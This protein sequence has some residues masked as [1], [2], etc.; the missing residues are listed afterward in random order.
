MRSIRSRAVRT[1]VRAI[2]AIGLATLTACTSPPTRFYTLG[3]APQP[4]IANGTA[5][6]SFPID[7]R[8]V[9]VPVAVARS[10]LV[11]Q[12]NPSQVKV[13]EDDRWA[14]SLQ[15]EIRYA[16]I[17]GVSQRAGAPG[18]SGAK[19][20]V[21]D[22]DV[23]DYQVAV[24]VQ[25]F[26]SWPDSHMLVDAVW[27]VRRSPDIETLICRSV[28]SEPV[29]G[30]YQAIV[31]G[32]RHAIG[33]IATQIAMMVRALAASERHSRLRPAGASGHAGKPTVSCTHVADGA[34]TAADGA[35]PRFV[36]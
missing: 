8:P 20:V 31:D 17:A 27:N 1:V 18:S 28:V 25:R 26:E 4:A 24:D 13:L 16:L 32:H 6:P 30:G 21:R 5:S 12:V 34:R 15:D 29:S 33:I 9:K 2:G 35:L 11:V 23:S 7:V 10:Q 3:T 36:E 14:S 22:E 19:A